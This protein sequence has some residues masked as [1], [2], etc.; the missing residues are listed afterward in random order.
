M[1]FQD[2]HVIILID[3]MPCGASV[4]AFTYQVMLKCHATIWHR[5]GL[6]WLSR[7]YYYYMKTLGHVL[8]MP[9]LACCAS[10]VGN[11]IPTHHA[12]LNC[13][14]RTSPHLANFKNVLEVSVF[15]L[16]S[17]R[18]WCGSGSKSRMSAS[19]TRAWKMLSYAMTGAWTVLLR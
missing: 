7:M 6:A 13:P 3:F 4:I 14:L 12:V 16:T 5:R 11:M 15:H 9:Y 2:I 19:T 17:S 1:I 10:G 18:S 8:I